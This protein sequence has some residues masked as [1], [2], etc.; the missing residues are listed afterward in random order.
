[1]SR[2]LFTCFIPLLIIFLSRLYLE[3]QQNILSKNSLQLGGRI[4]LLVFISCLMLNF[5]ALFLNCLNVDSLSYSSLTIFGFIVFLNSKYSF[6][7]F[8]NS[9]EINIPQAF[10]LL[11]HETSKNPM[12]F[13]VPSRPPTSP[14]KLRISQVCLFTIIQLGSIEHSIPVILYLD[15]KIFELDS[16]NR[17]LFN[18]QKSQIVYCPYC[19]Y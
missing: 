15:G 10:K 11:Y 1:M 12:I 19:K 9:N 2:S 4:S 16:F 3:L 6:P 18:F 14:K 17:P 5:N 7:D 8:L 13:N